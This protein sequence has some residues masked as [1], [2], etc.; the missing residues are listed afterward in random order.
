MEKKKKKG[1]FFPSLF[2][3]YYVSLGPEINQYDNQGMAW[4]KIPSS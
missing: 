1:V 4:K 2:Y 3:Y